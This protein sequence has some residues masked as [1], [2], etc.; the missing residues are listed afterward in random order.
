MTL[1]ILYHYSEANFCNQAIALRIPGRTILSANRDFS[2]PI[3]VMRPER[4]FYWYIRCF[5]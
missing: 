2:T 1:A 4:R 3:R 5:L